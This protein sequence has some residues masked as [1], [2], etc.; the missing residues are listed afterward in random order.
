MKLACVDRL[1]QQFVNTLTALEQEQL[2]EKYIEQDPGSLGVS[3]ARTKSEGVPVWALIGYLEASDG[4][5]VRVAHDYDLPSDAVRAAL[6]FY[7]RNP[8]VIAAR[9]EENRLLRAD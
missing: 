1:R 2:V 3:G 8:A 7:H 4:D 5:I 6:I 9:I